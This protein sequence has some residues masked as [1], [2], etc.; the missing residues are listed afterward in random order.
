[1]QSKCHLMPIQSKCEFAYLGKWHA[2][3]DTFAIY[4]LEKY[5]RNIC[6][7]IN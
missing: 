2:N 5:T 1:M 6:I 7:L 3:I 4:I